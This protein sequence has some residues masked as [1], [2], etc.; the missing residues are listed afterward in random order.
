MH[1]GL[2]FSKQLLDEVE[3]NF[4]IFRW[5]ITNYFPKLQ[6]RTILGNGNW[7]KQSGDS[8]TQGKFLLNFLSREQKLLGICKSKN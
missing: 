2:I 8:K 7:F 5:Q 3:Q 4:V 6:F 1:P